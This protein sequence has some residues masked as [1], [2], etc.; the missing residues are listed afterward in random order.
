MN[1]NARGLRL[2]TVE[3]HKKATELSCPP[4]EPSPVD[5]VRS[6]RLVQNHAWPPWPV[7]FLIDALRP[8]DFRLGAADS[9]GIRTARRY[10]SIHELVAHNR[11]RAMTDDHYPKWVASVMKPSLGSPRPCNDQ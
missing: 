6:Y 11:P 3:L 7:E 9:K 8:E 1:D 5:V 2:A 10:I 4:P